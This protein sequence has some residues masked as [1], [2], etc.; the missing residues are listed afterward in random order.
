MP[1]TS[2]DIVNFLKNRNQGITL[3]ARSESEFAKAHIPHAVNVS[4][5][6]DH[7]RH[8]VGTTYKQVGKQA[9][10]IKGFEL[11]GPKF[12]S[13]ISQI[14]SASQNKAIYLYCWRG[15]MRSNIMA[16]LLNMAGLNV[17]LL[18]GGYKTYRN[19]V[20]G[21]FQSKLNIFILGGK[22]GSGKS[23]ILKVL[24][25]KGQQVIDLEQLACHKGSAFGALGMPE[26][27]GTE[28]FEN[29]IAH[30]IE[31]LNP[32]LPIL[33]EN[34]SRQIGAVNIPEDFFLQMRNAPV[35]ELVRTKEDRILRILK[36]Y[37]D[38]PIQVLTQRTEMVKKRLGPDRT[39][40][41]I[42]LLMTGDMH[43]WVNLLL[44]Y[45]DKTYEYGL[46]TR[47]Q[48]PLSF[49]ETLNLDDDEVAANISLILQATY[50]AVNQ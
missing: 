2:L 29:L 50:N 5:L 18:E 30:T 37:G 47:H 8:I 16:W 1:I 20:L 9:A 26:Q 33:V 44:L 48:Q 31:L 28:H 41:A 36:D 7:A 4:I 12:S 32:D 14:L 19:H 46:E 49:V 27:P 25:S 6:D 15:G 42:E 45:Y 13:I 40:M 43:G 22:T 35:I 11:V 21:S 38:F 34:E 3:D 10:V 24:N 17:F 39:K 23:D